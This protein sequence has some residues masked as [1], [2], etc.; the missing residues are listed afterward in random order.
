M[1]VQ[2]EGDYISVCTLFTTRMI[3]ALGWAVM[4]AILIVRYINRGA[5]LIV[6]DNVTGHCP[7]V[8]KRKESRSRFEPRSLFLLA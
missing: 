4:R 3:P 2:K 7:Q 8:L 6:R 1:E 5:L